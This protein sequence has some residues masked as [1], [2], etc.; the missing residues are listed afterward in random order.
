MPMM[1]RQPIAALIRL[2]ADG[3]QRDAIAGLGG[4][5][6]LDP[7]GRVWFLDRLR[8]TMNRIAP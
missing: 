7:Q 8:G 3:M 1:Q 5:I 4:D 6:S 2:A